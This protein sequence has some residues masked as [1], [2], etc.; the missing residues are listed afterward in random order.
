MGDAGVVV[1]VAPA[2]DA[3]DDDATVVELDEPVTSVAVEPEVLAA[4]REPDV[5]R[6]WP[7]TL[8]DRWTMSLP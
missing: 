4:G 8:V 3:V 7:A 2:A 6:A 1:E 5:A